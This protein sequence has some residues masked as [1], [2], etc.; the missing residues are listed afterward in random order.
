MKEFE[1][2]QELAM[3]L[4]QEFCETLMQSMSIKGKINKDWT[5]EDRIG[6][7]EEELD[8]L[9]DTFASDITVEWTVIRSREENEELWDEAIED[10]PKKKLDRIKDMAVIGV[11]VCDEQ[12]GA[13]LLC[14]L[15]TDK[16]V[17]KAK[18]GLEELRELLNNPSLMSVMTEIK[19]RQDKEEEEND[20]DD[21]SS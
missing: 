20:G 14:E 7:A 13:L 3:L 11:T 19:K 21:V 17:E 6:F 5:V 18:K 9:N 1:R 16:K 12:I 8:C 4:A 15:K 2:H 10:L